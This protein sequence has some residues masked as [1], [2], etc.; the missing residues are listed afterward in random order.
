ML[1]DHIGAVSIWPTPLY[2][3][4]IGR[5]AF[6]IYAYMIAQGCRHTKNIN[7]YLLR[8]GIFA[9]ISEIPFDVAFNHYT[10]MDDGIPRFGINFL[11]YTNV[12]YTLFLGVAC[13]MIYEKL[14]TK[15]HQWPALLTLPF[16]PA[17]LLVN[18]FPSIADYGLIIATITMGLYTAGALCF[19][20]FLQDDD[21]TEETPFKKKIIPFLVALPLIITAGAFKTDYDMFGVGLIF[22]L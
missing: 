4:Y 9:L 19:A 11:R 10:L 22:L 14:K 15:K 20:N 8:L 18:F 6:P 7:K 3:R 1:V 5:I 13:I 17:I 21:K 2:F 12:F 16:I